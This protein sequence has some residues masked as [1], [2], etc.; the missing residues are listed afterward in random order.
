MAASGAWSGGGGGARSSGGGGSMLGSGAMGQRGG[1]GGALT[2]QAGSV[3]P[4]CL[5]VRLSLSGCD[6]AAVMCWHSG[7]SAVGKRA[8]RDGATVACGL[9]LRGSTA[10]VV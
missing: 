1:H 7:G 8:R 10:R 4:R 9:L 2:A 6:R 5:G 3:W